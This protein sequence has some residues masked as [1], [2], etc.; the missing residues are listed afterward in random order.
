MQVST[1]QRFTF[2]IVIIALCLVGIY[3]F[4]RFFLLFRCN[5]ET[6]ENFADVDVESD[7]RVEQTLKAK[8]RLRRRKAIESCD[9][10]RAKDPLEMD[11]KA[12]DMMRSVL[13]GHRLNAYKPQKGDPVVIENEYDPITKDYCYMYNDRENKMQDYMLDPVNGGC[14]MNNV[15]FKDMPFIN[16]VYSTPVRDY[17]H[18]V[19][20][21]KCILEIDGTKVNTDNLNTFWNKFAESSCEGISA[22]L[23]TNIKDVEGEKRKIESDLQVLL[24]EIEKYAN[25]LTEAKNNL[26]TCNDNDTR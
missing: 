4:S 2:V 20:V 25:D 8:S 23:R 19:P 6:I 3:I 22:P 18:A 7:E 5:K 17:T 13:D 16:K 26:S 1:F 15:L 12:Q 24:H 10:L 11:G 21:E 14:S 9:I